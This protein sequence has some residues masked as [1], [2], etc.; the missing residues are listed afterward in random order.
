MLPGETPE[1]TAVREAREKLGLEVRPGPLLA[2][3]ESDWDGTHFYFAAEP[4]GRCRPVAEPDPGCSPVWVELEATAG[5]DIRPAEV[6]RQLAR[7]V[8][9][10]E[11]RSAARTHSSEPFDLGVPA[12][13]GTGRLVSSDRGRPRRRRGHG[14]PGGQGARLAGRGEG[15]RG[16]LQGGPGPPPGRDPG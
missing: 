16:R 13:D 8:A 15:G 1:E 14:E 2:T 10:Q 9:R 5:L 4:V 6:G 7:L 3:W 12:T 11:R